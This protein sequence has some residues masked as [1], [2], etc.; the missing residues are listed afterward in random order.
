MFLFRRAIL[1]FV[2]NGRGI[3]T[4]LSNHGVPQILI[5][6]QWCTYRDFI[7]HGVHVQGSCSTSKC[8]KRL[9]AA[10]YIAYFP[11]NQTHYGAHCLRRVYKCRT[12]FTNT[13]IRYQYRSTVTNT[14]FL[15]RSNWLRGCYT[16]LLISIASNGPFQGNK[17]NKIRCFSWTLKGY[18]MWI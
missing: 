9:S 11:S 10:R 14:D 18:F 1:L 3:W 8:K 5:D 2:C 15:C 7:F 12:A 6:A 13:E 4:L 17:T 16:P